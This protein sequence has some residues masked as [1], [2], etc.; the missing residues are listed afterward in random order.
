[1]NLCI[2]IGPSS[3]SAII[4]SRAG[5]A[6]VICALDIIR[7]VCGPI[8]KQER[9]HTLKCI[10]NYTQGLKSMNSGTP[11]MSVYTLTELILNIIKM[12][13]SWLTTGIY[14]INEFHQDGGKIIEKANAKSNFLDNDKNPIRKNT[15]H[16]VKTGQNS[17][18]L[19]SIN[20]FNNSYLKSYH[21]R[22][23]HFGRRMSTLT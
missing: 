1:M 22:G 3:A 23:I 15:C 9:T 6:I 8:P 20:L 21:P 16:P 19:L 14:Q 5:E 17:I 7:T 2:K 13:D 11:E 18:L 4:V 12:K 10:S